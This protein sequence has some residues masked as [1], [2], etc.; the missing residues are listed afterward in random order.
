MS[1]CTLLESD[2]RV[3]VEL[4]SSEWP[5]EDTTGVN[6]SSRSFPMKERMSIVRDFI[7]NKNFVREK[8]LRRH[9]YIISF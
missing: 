6:Y 4:R 5:E 1:F 3:N 9:K 2:L 7:F 8:L